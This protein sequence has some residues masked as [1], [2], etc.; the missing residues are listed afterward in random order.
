MERTTRWVD[1]QHQNNIVAHID[2]QQFVTLSFELVNWLRAFTWAYGLVQV[3]GIAQYP[4]IS[5]YQMK[6]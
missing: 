2:P 6:R 1:S 3:D 4:H 5:I